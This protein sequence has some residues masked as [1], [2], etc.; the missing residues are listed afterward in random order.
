METLKGQAA[1]VTEADTTIGLAV[2]ETLLRRGCR[3]LLTGRATDQLDNIA[4]KYGPDKVSLMP[5]LASDV[6]ANSVRIV[7]TAVEKFGSFD[8][9]ICCTRPMVKYSTETVKPNVVQ[10]AWND[11]VIGPIQLIKASVKELSKCKG[12]VVLL[13]SFQCCKPDGL[14]QSLSAASRVD[15]VRLA[16]AELKKSNIRLNAVSPYGSQMETKRSQSWCEWMYS[17]LFMTPLG[18]DSRPDEVAELMAFAAAPDC[19]ASMT[20]N[21]F[22]IDGGVTITSPPS[23]S[24]I[25]TLTARVSNVVLNVQN[26]VFRFLRR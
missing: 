2:T 25:L 20:G 16:A 5:L 22:Y 18:R 23:Y 10:N 11:Q 15:L 1:I 3:V 13:S 7:N 26:K 17:L 14:L 12:S 24:A 19:L 9:L 8:Q 6:A 21:N 4:R